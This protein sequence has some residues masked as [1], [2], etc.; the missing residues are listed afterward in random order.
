MRSNDYKI[1]PFS[2]N[3]AFNAICARGDLAEPP[4]AAGCTDTK[5]VNYELYSQLSV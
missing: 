3:S 2:E 4:A 5:V 1:D